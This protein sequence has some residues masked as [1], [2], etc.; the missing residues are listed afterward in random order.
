MRHLPK[1]MSNGTNADDNIKC[2]PEGDSHSVTTI[3]LDER[4]QPGNNELIWFPNAPFQP[5]AEKSWT[6][7]ASPVR[8]GEYSSF[9]IKAWID[10]QNTLSNGNPE[11]ARMDRR[12]C[13]HPMGRNVFLIHPHLQDGLD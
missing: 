6:T 10:M 2:L 5:L 12:S 7:C 4:L 13:T 11:K 1:H 9:L 3:K 8:V